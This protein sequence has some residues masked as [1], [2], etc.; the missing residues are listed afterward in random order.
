MSKKVIHIVSH[1]H[2]DREWYMPFEKHRLKLVNLVD[3]CL[4]LFEK[5]ERFESFYLDGQSIVLDDYLEI[6]PEKKELIRN[7]ILE[8]KFYV[9]PWYILQ[10]EFL[11]SGESNVR[12]LLIGIE[13]AKAYGKLCKIG[14]FPD[15]FG[16]AG[17]M[18]QLLVQAG[19]DGVIFGRGVKPVGFQNEVIKTGEYESFYSEMLWNSPDGSSL[20]GIL[21]ANWYNNGAEIPVKEEE[22]KEYWD[23]KITDALRYVST[24]HLLFMNGCDHQPVQKDLAEAIAMANRLYPDYKFIHSNFKD[25]LQCI[26]ESQTNQLSVVT[27]EITS[28][29]TDGWTTLVNTT[30]S[31]IY[32][33]QLNRENEVTLA[34]ILEPMAALAAREGAAYPHDTLKYAWK[35]LMQNHPHDSI[36]GC[37]TDEVHQDMETRFHNS[38]QVSTS[39]IGESMEFLG[40][41]I[42][43]SPFKAGV[44]YPF[45][46]FNTTGWK[47]SK[48]VSV[49]V[50]VNRLYGQNLN[51]AYY[52]MKEI[53]LNHFVLK[54]NNGDIIPS[55]IKD[56]G[57]RFGYDLPKD[58]F[59]QPYMARY[60]TVTFEAEEIPAM[61]YSV[62]ALSADKRSEGAE[63]SL[64]IKDGM[65]NQ[66]L[67]VTINANGTI[68]LLDKSSGRYYENICYYED[69]GD[70]G[71]EYI[72]RQ[73][74]H[75]NR[76]LSK[77]CIADILLMEDKPYQAVY[78]ITQTMEI[79][80][81]AEDTLKEEVIS[82]TNVRYRK[83]KRSSKLKPLEITTY[84]TLEQNG[85]GLTV[86]T[87]FDN[88][89]KDHRFRVI[90]PT[91][92]VTD[93]HFTDSVFEVVERPNRHYPGWTN[94]SGCEHQQ[95]FTGIKDEKGGV[96][97]ANFGLYEYEILPEEKNAI[98]LTLL[99][100]VGELGDWG[101][102]LTPE[103]Q[104]QKKCT[105]T[106]AIIPFGGRENEL[107]PIAEAYQFQVPMSIDSLSIHPG[108]LPLKQSYLEW[109]GQGIYLTGMKNKQN[110]SDQILRFINGTNE[111]K[112]LMVKKSPKVIS[113]YKSNVI[114]EHKENLVANENG[115]IILTVKPYEI[116][117]IGLEV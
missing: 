24:D 47:R 115:R 15:A 14:Y 91:G 23:K 116:V 71:N 112:T 58:K 77:D 113:Y 55:D 82:M 35:K 111:I 93:R 96:V 59:R 33:K 22:A 17:Q 101:V 13:E 39:L 104:I 16:N 98:A 25:Y 92:I 81:S 32:L 42:D 18:P 60:I 5:D 87:E 4:E 36:C 73:P 99:R 46:V 11:T 52:K 105:A 64:V 117:T 61:G 8:D 56:G 31:R 76:L 3:D 62:Y 72:Y 6:K 95:C 65:E 38:L 12:N 26:K 102:F 106:F 90:I 19:M 94:P 109:E 37:S 54:D 44:D 7:K 68:N 53:N 107:D 30:S 88:R 21:F 41:K 69:T 100:A 83:A 51:A 108:T 40:S 114:E 67:K 110:S 79:P 9:G 48:V 74:D 28:Q 89:M 97:V 80:E 1:S 86:R 70:I 75:D 10:D 66:C 78:K 63:H 85:R 27:G 20:L 49:T 103:A 43:T 29:M 50:D 34:N 84:L 2:W 57:V 45:V